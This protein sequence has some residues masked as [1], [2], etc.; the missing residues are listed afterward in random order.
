[1]L[2]SRLPALPPPYRPWRLRVALFTLLIAMISAT[3]PA[4]RATPFPT[5]PVEAFKAVLTDRTKMPRNDKPEADKEEFEKKMKA[6]LEVRDMELRTA[7][8]KLVSIDQLARAIALKDSWEKGRLDEQ[9]VE[10]RD[11][12]IQSD[13]KKR[14]QATI[15]TQ[16][17]SKDPADQVAT[18]VYLAETAGD[19]RRT[20]PPNLPV[21]QLC[22]EQGPL[23]IQAMKGS[24]G[25][26]L[27]TALRTLGQI[28]PDPRLAM[29]VLQEYLQSPDA[30]VRMASAD[31]IQGGAELLSSAL[32]DCCRPIRA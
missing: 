30:D 4:A 31:A 9:I 19:A 12:I 23:V 14:L 6:A 5:D 20:N 21:V 25:I 2:R 16:L 26:V 15:N 11:R 7:A 27:Q 8:A 13:L 29:P 3:L 32:R 28:Q 10:D 17:T 22:R 1:M 18:L 24:K